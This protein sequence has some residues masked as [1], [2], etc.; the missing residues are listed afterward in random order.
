MWKRIS[1]GKLSSRVMLVAVVC[2][3]GDGVERCFGSERL[4]YQ[5]GETGKLKQRDIPKDKVP[6][7]QISRS[8]C[9]TLP[10]VLAVCGVKW[11]FLRCHDGEMLLRAPVALH[12]PPRSRVVSRVHAGQG[13]PA[14]TSSSVPL[15]LC[16]TR[17]FLFC[18]SKFRR[19]M[20]S[21]VFE[22][23]GFVSLGCANWPKGPWAFAIRYTHRLSGF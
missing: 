17:Y 1:K 19:V 21:P 10:R 16:T 3:P 6:T 23:T 9:P 8:K 7:Q 14:P 12:A 22:R 13:Y 18:S 11:M 20:L 5:T 2:L 15:P 4:F